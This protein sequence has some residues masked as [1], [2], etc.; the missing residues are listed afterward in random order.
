MD[1]IKGNKTVENAESDFLKNRL[2]ALTEKKRG[3]KTAEKPRSYLNEPRTRALSL[4]RVCV[5]EGS[6]C[7]VEGVASLQSALEASTG[8]QDGETKGY[9]ASNWGT[10]TPVSTTGQP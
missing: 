5:E 3:R 2:F 8:S 4:P 9:K 1:E 6:R 10:G 7:S